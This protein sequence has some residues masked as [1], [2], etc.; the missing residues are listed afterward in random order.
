MENELEKSGMKILMKYK[1]VVP[2][3]VGVMTIM[4]CNTPRVLSNYAGEIG[5]SL[6]AYIPW[7]SKKAVFPMMYV[8]E[9][10]VFDY[11][12]IFVIKGDSISI[13]NTVDFEYVSFLFKK[14]KDNVVIYRDNVTDVIFLYNKD[15]DSIVLHKVS[16][17]VIEEIQMRPSVMWEKKNKK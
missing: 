12:Y 5:D 1:F 10:H 2:M 4:G 16:E 8:Q 6:T 7:N 13:C 9:H 15:L 17:K 3:I 14:N 11:P